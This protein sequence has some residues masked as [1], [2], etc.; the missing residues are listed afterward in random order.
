MLREPAQ[1]EKERATRILGWSPSV[2]RSVSGGYTPA[3]RY[4]VSRGRDRAFVKVATTP[5]TAKQLRQECF[6]Y[7]RLRGPFMPQFVG[8]SDDELAPMLIIEDLSDARWPPP[9]DVKLV[10]G[11]LENIDGL[12]ASRTELRTFQVAHDELSL[13]WR[14]VAEN[15][16]PFLDLGVVSSDWLYRAL[17]KLREAEGACQMSGT[18]VT[19]FDLRSDNICL[20]GSGIKFID[21]AEACNGDP[22][23][24]IGFWLPS[25]CFEGGPQPEELLPDSP[26]IAAWVSGYFAARAGLPNIPDGPSCGGSN[27]SSYPLRCHGSYAP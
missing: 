6:A 27:A 7:E 13:G 18:S 22:N 17:A 26:N 2:W 10:D 14:M 12:H 9:W 3:A 24:D 15:P 8:W 20:A 4:V 25:L 19:H 16:R 5:L 21:W 1:S 23:L 11:V